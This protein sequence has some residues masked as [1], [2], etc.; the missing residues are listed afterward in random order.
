MSDGLAKLSECGADGNYYFEALE[1]SALVPY[2]EV[3][4]FPFGILFRFDHQRLMRF[5]MELN[6]LSFIEIGRH[7]EV[8][9]WT[10]NVEL[11]GELLFSITVK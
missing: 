3:I 1:G 11:S 7:T 10:N 2:L 5:Q 6:Q 9:V 4:P 8:C